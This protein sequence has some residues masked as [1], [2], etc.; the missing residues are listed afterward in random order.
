MMTL[1]LCLRKRMRSDSVQTSGFIGCT[2]CSCFSLVSH[3]ART[4]EGMPAMSRLYLLQRHA[5][6][7]AMWGILMGVALIFGVSFYR[8]GHPL[9][10]GQRLR[11]STGEREQDRLRERYGL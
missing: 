8:Y 5:M 9:E 3:S 1:T 2:M 6:T 11:Q 10:H 4:V 7:Y